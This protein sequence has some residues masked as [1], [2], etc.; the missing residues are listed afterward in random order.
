VF[1]RAARPVPSGI[2]EGN[3]ARVVGIVTNHTRLRYYCSAAPY[4]GPVGRLRAFLKD[5]RATRG[6]KT[7]K[8]VLDA[9]IK[10]G[11]TAA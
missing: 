7:P 2:D 4:L 11:T 10:R 6:C 5:R 1:Q 8:D 9:L 3:Y